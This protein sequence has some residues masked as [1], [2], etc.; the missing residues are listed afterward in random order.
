MVKILQ[1]HLHSLI[2]IEYAVLFKENFYFKSKPTPVLSNK[3]GMGKS[4]Y[5]IGWS[6]FT[7]LWS[8]I[9]I[10]VT[11]IYHIDEITAPADLPDNKIN[12]QFKWQRNTWII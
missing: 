12:T 4:E 7:E 5:L 6:M 2:G 1:L 8:K 11:F 9:H 3:T 10:D